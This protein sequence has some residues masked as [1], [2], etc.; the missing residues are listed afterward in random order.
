MLCFVCIKN[1]IGIF[2][3]IFSIGV[4]FEFIYRIFLGLGGFGYLYVI[5]EVI[6]SDVF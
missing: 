2:F 1:V 5:F 4:F 6:I 3:L